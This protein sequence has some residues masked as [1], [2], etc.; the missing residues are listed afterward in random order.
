MSIRGQ[1]QVEKKYDPLDTTLKF[2]DRPDDL[3]PLCDESL[4]AE[5]SC[6]HAVTPES[7]TH[8]CHTQLEEGNYK[9]RCPAL[10]DGTKQC[11]K[12]WSY[13]EVRRLADLTVEEMQHFE[14]SMARLAVTEYCEVQ[15][16]PQCKT[17]VERKDLSNL[18]VQCVVCTADQKKTYQFCWQ[19]LKQWKGPGPRSDRCNNDGCEN[20][21][22]QLLQTCGT[23][24]LPAVK[25]VTSCPSVRVCPTCGLRVEHNREYCKNIYCPRCR[26]QFCFVCLKLKSECSQTSSP[27]E[28]CPSG[29]APRQTSIPVWRKT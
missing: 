17:S 18:C 13:Q 1:E 29:V 24:S 11:N 16:C 7:L 25:G 27:Y 20:K 28:I 3:D 19:Y 9:F 21:D 5:M 12:V 23:I 6:G 14:E 4:R 26:V 8:W 10:V 15:P 2:V 22:L